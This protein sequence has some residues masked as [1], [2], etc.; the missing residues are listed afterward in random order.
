MA[1]LATGLVRRTRYRWASLWTY[2]LR[3]LLADPILRRISCP[4]SRHRYAHVLADSLV[5]SQLGDDYPELALC[6]RCG[7]AVAW[8]N[9]QPQ[10]G[11]GG[12][13]GP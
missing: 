5:G 9:G 7:Q 6:A 12:P 11:S 10:L 2:T 1:G 8:P 3:P 13:T 4:R